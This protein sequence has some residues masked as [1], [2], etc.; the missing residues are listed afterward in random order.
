MQ[1]N[2]NPQW[3][4]TSSPH[5]RAPRTTQKIMLDVII[6][7]IPAGIAGTVIFGYRAA[8]LMAI[9]VV[10]AVFWEALAQKLM[11]KPIT[12]NDLSA[13][14]TG[15]LLAYNLPATVPYWIPVVGTLIAIVLVKQ[16]F[17]GI[18]QNFIN[19][20]LLSRAVLLASWTGLMSSSAF[21]MDAV[22]MATPLV[23]E[24]GGYGYKD[25][26]LGNIP[27]CIGETC[28]L[29]LLI[30]GAYL[31]V[32]RVIDWRIPAAMMG[33][34][35]ICFLISSGNLTG[36]VDSALYQ[37]LSGGLILG[38]LFMATDY[39]TSPVTPVGRLIM[40]VGCGLL[41]F[42]IRTYNS[43]YPEGFSYA[44]LVMNLCTPLIDRFTKPR[45][46]GG[47]KKHA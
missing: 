24:W 11:K 3:R 28:K 42:L 18:G 46:Y 13:V 45:I 36:S 31:L 30:G 23:A 2:G 15:L 17:G 40:G 29:A 7:L 33:T 14:V 22:S 4:V 34:V 8:I 26:L 25:L 12:I 47:G 6:A 1:A 43:T 27:G 19:P 39:A 9:S 44:I 38:A 35:C 21:Q 32:R 20:A 10:S 5:I 41:I 16:L 37:L